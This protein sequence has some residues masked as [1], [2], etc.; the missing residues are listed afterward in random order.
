MKN[1]LY[2]TTALVAAGALAA[3]SA[4]GAE[5]IKMGVGGYMQA[6][7]VGVDNKDDSFGEPGNGLRDHL[8][9]R[10]GEIIF[11]GV[12][13]FDNGLKVGAQ[14]QLEAETCGDQIDE[15]FLFFSGSWGRINLGSENSAA[16]LMHYSSPAP[17]H[18]AHGLQSSNF[19]HANAPGNAV[20]NFV[21]TSPA[22]LSS[23][24][25]K[26]TYFTPRLSGF[27]FGVSYSPER[28]EE[29]NDKDIGQGAGCG[30]SYSGAESEIDGV[31]GEVIEFGVNYVGNFDDVS[32]AVSGSWGTNDAELGKKDTDEWSVGT[33]IGIAGFTI[34]AG[35]RHEE[36]Q[37]G[38]DG[39]NRDDFTIGVRYATGPWGVG[40]QYTYAEEDVAGAGDDEFDGVEV[41]GSY[42]LGPGVLLSGGIQYLDWSSDDNAHENEAWIGFIGT[43]VAF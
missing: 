43:H 25:E 34:G 18:W 29:N 39:I 38:V 22:S 33:S 32:I 3:G 9:A 23:D 15:T 17:S 24:S 27:Q 35:Y 40:V 31:P 5:K 26:I 10:E 12:T 7:F 36:D 2:C 30:G 19:M 14:V 21:H 28:C 13:T 41:G 20:G 1:L 4:V 11:N 16:Y 42:T 37:G 6:F 8:V